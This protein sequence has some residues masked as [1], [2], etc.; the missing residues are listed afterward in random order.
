MTEKSSGD[1]LST[2]EAR[3]KTISDAIH[4]VNAEI[5]A[6]RK[7]LEY[8]SQAKAAIPILIVGKT[9]TGCDAQ[10]M[11]SSAKIAEI[12]LRNDYHIWDTLGV[13]VPHYMWGEIA[14]VVGL[15]IVSSVDISFKP[16]QQ[17]KDQYLE[18]KN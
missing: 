4:L 14:Q 2:K 12:L 17:N 10:V 7:R 11:E 9:G 16:K 8:I 13:D 15:G 1:Q 6:A 5:E 3:D 18:H